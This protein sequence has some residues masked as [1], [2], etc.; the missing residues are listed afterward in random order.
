[1]PK[2]PREQ[3]RSLNLLMHFGQGVAVGAVRGILANA[4]LRG[5]WSSVMFTVVRLTS[6]Q[7]LENATGV[8]AP[9]W[10]WPRSELV[11][12]L[13]HKSIYAFA[14][15]IVADSLAW[16]YGKR[17]GEIHA[18]LRPGGKPHVGPAPRP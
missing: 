4:G 7:I 18:E 6:D 5:P 1:M 13:V 10:T 11:V 17:P 15:G 16:R 9:P 8:G 3:P 2:Q 14:A 12:D